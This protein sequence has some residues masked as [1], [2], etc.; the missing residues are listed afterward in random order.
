MKNALE[1]LNR[2]NIEGRI[3][4]SDYSVLFDAIYSMGAEKQDRWISVKDK[5]MPDS[6]GYTCLVCAVNSFG[7]TN[8]FEAFTPYGSGNW[9]TYDHTKMMDCKCGDN[10]VSLV[11]KITHWMPLPEPPKGEDD[12][13][14]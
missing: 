6:A 4:Y 9:L 2:M 8:V 7:Q 10:R 3:E 12:E 5:P 14:D 1:V 13:Q 11:W